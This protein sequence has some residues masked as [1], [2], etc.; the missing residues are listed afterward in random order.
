[1]LCYDP[2]IKLFSFPFCISANWIS[3]FVLNIYA[4]IRLVYG[5]LNVLLSLLF[6]YETYKC[7]QNNWTSFL[8]VCVC[9]GKIHQHHYPCTMK[10]ASSTI[11]R[12]NKAYCMVWVGRVSIF[13]R[14]KDQLIIGKLLGHDFERR[15]W[16]NNHAEGVITLVAI[17]TVTMCVCACLCVCVHTCWKSMFNTRTHPLGL[18][19]I[20][21]WNCDWKN[22]RWKLAKCSE[23]LSHIKQ[24]ICFGW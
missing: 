10:S 8:C 22:Y 6:M 14:A 3:A 1:M 16:F 11:N 9:A 13:T 5:N 21:K 20:G 4:Y 12:R 17:V 15:I 7:L 24:V 23:N 2:N 19:E 18:M